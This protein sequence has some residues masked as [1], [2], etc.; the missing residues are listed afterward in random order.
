MIA[1]EVGYAVDESRPGGVTP[2]E[3]VPRA[4]AAALGGQEMPGSHVADVDEVHRRVDHRRQP[5]AKVAAD[6]AGRG[7]TGPGAIEGH[8]EHVGGIDDHELD[9]VMGR[10]PE[11]D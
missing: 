9:A 4:G 11:G 3:D 7:L 2:A 1:G 5:A 10:R 6:D 8:P